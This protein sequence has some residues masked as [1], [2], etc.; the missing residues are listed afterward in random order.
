ML[1]LH[2]NQ[3]NFINLQLQEVDLTVYDQKYDLGEMFSD[4]QTILSLKSSEH[5]N[6]NISASKAALAIT[7]SPEVKSFK[8]TAY[9]IFDFLGEVGGLNDILF[10]FAKMFLFL[11]SFCVPANSSQNI[12]KRV[13]YEDDIREMENTTNSTS[14]WYN[15]KKKFDRLLLRKKYQPMS[16]LEYCFSPC[17]RVSRLKTHRDAG[18]LVD[19]N[20]DVASFIKLSIK[21][22]AL[23]RV[24]MDKKQR[25]LLSHNR[26]FVVPYDRNHGSST[27]S[28]DKDESKRVE[29]ISILYAKA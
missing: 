11:F 20:L 14:E 17:R 10:I 5:F 4:H 9:T 19:R 28:D 21:M 29:D 27:S 2:D 18:A 26:G 3:N 22:K 7:L 6:Q 13:F 1:P 23:I 15:V 24:L 8:R 16:C 25:L 12:A